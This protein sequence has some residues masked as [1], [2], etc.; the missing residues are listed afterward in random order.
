MGN[1][2]EYGSV[3]IIFH[4]FF[5]LHL[6]QPVGAALL[7][8]NHQNMVGFTLLKNFC[9]FWLIYAP[10]LATT[11]KEDSGSSQI[12][13]NVICMGPNVNFSCLTISTITRCQFV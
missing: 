6:L 13:P 5:L 2:Y 9:F 7:F 3:L 1:D 11:Q 4:S 8:L 12:Y 10:Q